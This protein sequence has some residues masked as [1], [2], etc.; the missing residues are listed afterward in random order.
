MKAGGTGFSIA[1]LLAVAACDGS[2]D[3]GITSSVASINAGNS[4]RKPTAQIANQTLASVEAELFRSARTTASTRRLPSNREHKRIPDSY[5][6][7]I[8]PW[9]RLCDWD[10]WLNGHA[11]KRPG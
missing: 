5:L 11:A 6:C 1:I 3:Q 8:N 9:H 10:S 4:I 2:S 7:P